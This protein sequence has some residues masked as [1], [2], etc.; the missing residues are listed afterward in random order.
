MFLCFLFFCFLLGMFLLM[1]N[2][3]IFVFVLILLSRVRSVVLFLGEGLMSLLV[4]VFFLLGCF[5]WLLIGDVFDSGVL[6]WIILWFMIIFSVV[7]GF[8]VVGLVLDVWF[9]VSGRELIWGSWRE[10]VMV[11]RIDSDGSLWW[12]IFGVWGF[13]GDRWWWWKFWFVGKS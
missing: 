12:E 7:G 5:M 11:I 4:Y 9:L 8:M 2:V 3:F 1:M 6:I 10:L 13:D